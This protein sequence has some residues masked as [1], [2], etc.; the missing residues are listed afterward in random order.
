MN[1]YEIF[2]KVAECGN[3]TKCAQ[4]VHYTQAGISHAIAALEKE[5][6]LTLFARTARGV[7]LTENGRRLLPSIQALVNDQHALTQV[8]NQIGGVVA[9]T[10]RVGTFTSVSMQWLP[11]LI[12]NF[13][14]RHPGVEFDL[15]AGDYDQITEMLMAGKV[16]CGFLACARAR[17]TRILP[18][19]PRP[20][21]GV[22]AQRTPP[23][24]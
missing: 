9:G 21:V 16:D 24:P 17:R 18:A 3:I 8:I 2:L 11:R 6:G 1:R 12:Q 13:T 5:T 19:L 14:A 20:H 15:Q 23:C 7:T 4:S 22:F 10:L